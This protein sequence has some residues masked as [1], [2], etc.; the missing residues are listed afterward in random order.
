MDLYQFLAFLIAIF[1]V[2]PTIFAIICLLTINSITTSTF[3]DASAVQMPL[4]PR[5]VSARESLQ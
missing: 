3:Q 4:P 5:I 1:L 2:V